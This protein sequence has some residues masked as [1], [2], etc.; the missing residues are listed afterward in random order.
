M[1][2]SATSLNELLYELRRIEKSREV[3]TE[4]KIRKI[5]RRLMKELNAFVSETYLKYEDD[6]GR[7][8]LAEL[9]N[10]AKYA[11]FLEEV[12]KQVS[13]V[14]PTLKKEIL[15]LVDS[16]YDACYKK[17]IEAT[18]VAAGHKAYSEIL[19]DSLI[20]PDVMRRAMNNNIS[21]LTLPAVL[22]RN[23]Q[24]VIYQIQQVIN[25]GLMNGDRYDT[26]AKRIVERI[27]ISYHKAVLT[28][29]TESHRNIEAGIRDSAKDIADT[30]DGS[31]LVYTATWRTMKD[32]KVRPQHRVH[33]AKRGW[34]TVTYGQADHVKMEGQIIQV[35]DRFDLGN[36]AHAECPG[37]SGV[38]AHDCNC[39]C[40]LEYKLMTVEEFL[41]KGGKLLEKPFT[42]D[43]KS[44]IINIDGTLYGQPIR[45]SVGAKSSST[46]TVYYPG[47]DIQVD[48]VEG[49]RPV[50]PPDHTMA[51]YGCKTHRQIDDIDRLVETYNCSAE[52]WQKEKARFEVYDEYGEIRI[53]ELHWYQHPDTGKVEYKVKVKG[54]SFY[55][56]EW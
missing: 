31:G 12:T 35:G 38:A 3:L 32:E 16:T 9:K 19:G 2:K 1:P 18:K 39:R 53:V 8:T 45:N 17:M 49:S 20:A 10:K 48:F 51:G 46:P 29:R 40:F 24:E 43:S 50:Y 22:E 52:R 37:S 47:T 27:D 14:S 23:R 34:R 28:A 54:G 15:A 41:E 5:Y 6:D 30:L 7:L 4:Q 36:G 55:V 44:D 56:D 11:R 21:K 33:S 25:I 42:N 26:M 13:A